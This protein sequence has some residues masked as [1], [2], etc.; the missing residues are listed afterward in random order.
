[1]AIFLS[2]TIVLSKYST[3][4]N[5]KAQRQNVPEIRSAISTANLNKTYFKQ[6]SKVVFS[7]IP[8]CKTFETIHGIEREK[9]K[10]LI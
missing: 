4:I 9:W 6:F 8:N 1:M 7:L 2:F 5:N 3:K 10:C